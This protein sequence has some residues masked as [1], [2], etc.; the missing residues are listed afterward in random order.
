MKSMACHP[1]HQEG[2]QV[3]ME[4]SYAGRLR[5]PRC[6][7]VYGPAVLVIEPTR[8]RR[9]WIPP[10]LRAPSFELPEP[11]PGGP[12]HDDKETPSA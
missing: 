10:R 3:R 2:V 1:C 6:G 7:Y 5:C 12:T 9:R 8:E 4:S 11:N